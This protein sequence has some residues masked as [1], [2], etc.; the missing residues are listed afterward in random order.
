MRPRKL[1]FF[2]LETT[3]F[4]WWRHSIHQIGIM[5][6]IDGVVVEKIDIKLRP[7]PGAPIEQEALDACGVTLEQIMGYQS[8][9]AG[10]KQFREVLRKY[11]DRYDKTDK[12]YLVGYNNGKFDNEFLVRLFER[13]KD[14]MFY[15][16]FW[17]NYLDVVVLASQL[18]IDE[19][20]DMPSFKLHRVARTLGIEVD[21]EKLHDALYDVELT[22]ELYNRITDG[23]F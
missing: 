9:E 5:V 11:V 17:G 22:R 21:E 19:R 18:L 7:F 3:G 15:S 13:N 2:D 12:F 8:Q 10:F 4:Y 6:E 16:Y 1:L 14:T 23:C 20:V